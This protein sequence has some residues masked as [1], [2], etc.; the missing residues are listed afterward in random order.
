MRAASWHC[1]YIA[2]R[3]ANKS[4][5]SATGEE[6]NQQN[7]HI[8]DQDVEKKDILRHSGVPEADTRANK[9]QENLKNRGLQ[10]DQPGNPV[11]TTGSTRKDQETLPTGEP[12]PGEAKKILKNNKTGPGLG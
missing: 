1:F 10:E 6:R 8:R 11:R 7:P 12:D 5:K 4:S 3:M 9:D 2:K